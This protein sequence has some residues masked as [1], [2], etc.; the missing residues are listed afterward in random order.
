MGLGQTVSGIAFSGNESYKTTHP[1]LME[2]SPDGGL[3]GSGADR[4]LAV[5]RSEESMVHTGY[6]Y[7]NVRGSLLGAFF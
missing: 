2:W 3:V 7:Q 1:S 5:K 6:K 4:K